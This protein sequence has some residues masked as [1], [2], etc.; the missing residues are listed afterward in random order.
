MLRTGFAQKKACVFLSKAQSTSTMVRSKQ[1]VNKV[2]NS[3]SSGPGATAGSSSV[4]TSRKK[5]SPNA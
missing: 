5:R 4:N 3:D 1:Q 2:K